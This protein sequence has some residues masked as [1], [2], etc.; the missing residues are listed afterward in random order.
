MSL[1]LHLEIL[2]EEA[3]TTSCEAW[4]IRSRWTLSLG[5]DRAGPC[6]VCGGKDRFA[7][8]RIKNTFNCRRCG[9]A[10]SGVIELVMKVQGVGFTRACEV[11][12]GRAADAPID[13]R[14]A[15]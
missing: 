1:P 11:I 3:L 8:H 10:G 5:V 9:L 6:P 7:I 13:E 15:A 2:R 4:A 12:T 14:Q